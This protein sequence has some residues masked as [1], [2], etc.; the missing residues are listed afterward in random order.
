MAY[1]GGGITP[2]FGSG[3]ALLFSL[4]RE[5]D[6]LFEDAAGSQPGGTRWAPAVDV[7]EDEN[8]VALDVELPGIQPEE[9]EVSVENGTLMIRGEKRAERK[10]GDGG[11]YH[12]VE[13]TYGS[14]S[15]SFQLPAGIDENQIEADFQNGVLTVRI[16]KAAL[17]RPRRIE[18]GTGGQGAQEVKGGREP[19]AST[20][21]SS[22]TGSGSS[23]TQRGNERAAASGPESQNEQNR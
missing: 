10:E 15:R 13:R 20:R 8:S 11:R 4:R 6:R 23:R 17:P 14:F 9:V 22:R 18:I 1:R 7:R 5:S 2:F 19:A 16:P 3:F 21:S 12:S